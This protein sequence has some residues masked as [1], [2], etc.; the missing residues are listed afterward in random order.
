MQHNEKQL[1]HFSSIILN[2]PQQYECMR[3]PLNSLCP[4]NF[5]PSSQAA[6]TA[7]CHTSH[8][9]PEV[10]VEI[11]IKREM[12]HHNCFRRHI[13][14]LIASIVPRYLPEKKW[15]RKPSPFFPFLQ[16][17]LHERCSHY[18]SFIRASCRFNA[19]MLVW[20]IWIN[21]QARSH[22]NCLGSCCKTGLQLRTII[23][24]LLIVLF[25]V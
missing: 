15:K 19:L 5:V 1:A 11:I 7:F 22:S 9:L 3:E 2:Q 23:C 17:Y 4:R 12:L 14:H 25:T 20:A 8:H 10:A 18:Y 21:F 13:V 6:A 16:C 24:L